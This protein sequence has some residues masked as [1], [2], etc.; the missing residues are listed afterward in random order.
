MQ[1]D[2]SKGGQSEYGGG[3]I[4]RVVVRRWSGIP[5]ALG[6]AA[7]WSACRDWYGG[8][9]LL[10]SAL[11]FNVTGTFHDPGSDVI[12]LNEIH[13][14]QPIGIPELRYIYLKYRDG[15]QVG[16]GTIYYQATPPFP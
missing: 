3:L 4:V 7:D 6:P 15:S 10:I 14:F 12:N 11:G 5:H 2:A 16:G 1:G 13:P 9:I 8:F